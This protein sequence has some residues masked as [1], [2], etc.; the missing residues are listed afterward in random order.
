ML[1]SYR[2]MWLYVMFDLPTNTLRER[3]QARKFREDLLEHSFS[4]V[5][6]SV[7]ARHFLGGER[8]LSM[9][10]KIKKRIPQGGRIDMLT[11]TDKQFSNVVTFENNC[12]K[13]NHGREQIV[14][15]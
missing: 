1:S 7:Y 2:V 6:F 4:M 14:F 3:E 12:E 13:K 9:I 11:I 8:V 15:F 10:E 5:Q